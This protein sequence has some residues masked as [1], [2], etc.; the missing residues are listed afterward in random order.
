MTASRG[1]SSSEYFWFAFPQELHNLGVTIRTQAGV[2]PFY[3]LGYPAPSSTP[4]I[5]SV[6]ED[7]VTYRLYRRSYPTVAT[8][9]TYQIEAG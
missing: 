2:E 8:T 4:A 9:L 5:G 7:G 1:S 6:V 3:R